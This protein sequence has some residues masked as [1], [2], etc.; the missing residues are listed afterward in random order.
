MLEG[1]LMVKWDEDVER[2]EKGIRTKFKG[3]RWRY[4]L[5]KL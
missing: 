2:R 5:F 1:S 4:S 3:G